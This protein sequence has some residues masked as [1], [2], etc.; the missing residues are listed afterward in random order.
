MDFLIYIINVLAWSVT[1]WFIL[2]LLV[3]NRIKKQLEPTLQD[4]ERERLIP[5]TVEVDQDQYFCY[6]CFTKAFVCQGRDM[7][8]IIHRFKQRYPDKSAAIYDGD[9]VAVRTLKSQLETLAKSNPVQ[10]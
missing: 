7:Q 2:V 6:N 8:E 1:A 4:L 3:S 9:E 10:P 5:L